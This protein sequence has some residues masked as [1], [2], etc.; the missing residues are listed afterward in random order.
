MCATE[1]DHHEYAT[2]RTNATV[3]GEYTPS[4]LAALAADPAFLVLDDCVYDADELAAD[5]ALSKLC[6]D[7]RTTVLLCEQ[8]P[9]SSVRI[10][11]QVDYTFVFKEP[12]LQNRKRLFEASRAFESFELFCAAMDQCGPFECYVFDR[13]DHVWWHKAAPPS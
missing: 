7:E 3:A 4:L 6:S 10:R 8:Y 5:V 12:N 11:D 9:Y 13:S 1:H 2:F